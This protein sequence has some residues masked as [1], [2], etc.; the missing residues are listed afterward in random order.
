MKCNGVSYKKPMRG[1]SGEKIAVIQAKIRNLIDEFGSGIIS[2]E[3]FNLLYERYSK[4]LAALLTAGQT[5]ES[6]FPERHESTVALRIASAGQIVGLG[7]YHHRSGHIIDTQGAFQLP[8]AAINSVLDTFS[9]KLNRREY[10]EPCFKQGTDGQWLVF[11][12][13]R[14]TT[15]ILI[16][17]NQPSQRQI[18]DFQR[19]HHDYEEANRRVLDAPRVV[20]SKLVRPFNSL[21]DLP[22][23][24]AHDPRQ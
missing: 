3:Q 5:G 8:P 21:N 17:Q 9:D 20:Q 22:K 7:M 12:A 11:L 6:A 2:T 23:N 15:M 24:H 14:Y 16:F 18:V 10:I 19:L 4:Q 1:K 13:R